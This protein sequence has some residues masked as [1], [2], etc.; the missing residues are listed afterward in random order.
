ML[1]V[2][3]HPV[4]PGMQAQRPAAAHP[5]LYLAGQSERRHSGRLAVR[6]V[7]PS[8]AVHVRCSAVRRCQRGDVGDAVVLAVYGRETGRRF[9]VRLN[10]LSGSDSG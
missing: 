2:F 9:G 5:D 10:V 6:P 4:G 8:S 3:T 1:F 7:R